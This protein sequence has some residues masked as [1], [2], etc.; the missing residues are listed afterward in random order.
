MLDPRRRAIRRASFWKP[1]RAVY[2]R[3]D[4]EGLTIGPTFRQEV[5]M[6]R[7]IVECTDRALRGMEPLDGARDG[8]MWRLE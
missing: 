6:T 5:E 1:R 4:K 8:I 2:H 7:R 3:A